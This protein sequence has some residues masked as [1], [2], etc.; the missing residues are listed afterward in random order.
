MVRMIMLLNCNSFSFFLIF[1]HSGKRSSKE[2]D[3]SPN[4]VISFHVK[5]AITLCSSLCML[6]LLY[7]CNRTI[8]HKYDFISL[9]LFFFVYKHHINMLKLSANRNCNIEN[10]KK[11]VNKKQT[12]WHFTTFIS[13]TKNCYITILLYISTIYVYNLPPSYFVDINAAIIICW[14]R[15][16]YYMVIISHI[17]V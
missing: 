13:I 9:P 11:Y 3:R 2:M 14:A 12:S 7:I 4:K 1:R 15:F 6:C 17:S 16:S 10:K 5:K 8:A